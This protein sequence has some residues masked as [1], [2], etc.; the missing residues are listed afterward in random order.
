MIVAALTE[1]VHEIPA[2]EC[3]KSLF[4]GVGMSQFPHENLYALM[5]TISQ[6]SPVQANV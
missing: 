4:E 5:S 2:P 3:C 1:R 6:T